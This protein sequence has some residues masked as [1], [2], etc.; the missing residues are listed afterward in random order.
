[1]KYTKPGLSPKPGRANGQRGKIKKPAVKAL[2]LAFACLLIL[3]GS[4][5]PALAGERGF[6]AD[7]PAAGQ[8]DGGASLTGDVAFL[9]Q[10]NGYYVMQVTV[11][12]SG[13][14]F[15]GT[16]QVVF[17]SGSSRN[18]AY[19]TQLTLPSQGK[20]QFTIHVLER[21][22]DVIRG[23]CSLNFLNEQG[24]LLQA[25]S[26]KNVFG[27]TAA[28]I[29]VG[30]L[31]EDYAGLT[32][33]DAGGTELYLQDFS[34]PLAL[35]ELTADNLQ[36]HLSG[37]Y[38]LVIDQFEVAALGEE[39]I[40]ALED[41]VL[42]GGCL[43]IGTGA[44]AEE[45][46]SGL[47][48]ELLGVRLG[49]VSEPGESNRLSGEMDRYG[50]YWDYAD[51]EV[52]FT[53]MTVAE[54][55]YSQ[56]HSD[57]FESNR[58]PAAVFSVGSG[59]VSVF[60]LSFG[61]EELQNL[62][63]SAI[64]ALYEETMYQSGRFQSTNGQSNMDY[65]GMRSLAF[66][67]SLHSNVDFKWLE[68]LIGVYVAAAGPVLYLILRKQKKS[69]WYWAAAPVLSL[70]FVAGV[71]FFGQGAR[72][73]EMKVYSITAQRADGN[74]EATSIL[75]YRSG[76]SP[77]E[78]QLEERYDV[79]G[80][81]WSGSYYY[82]NTNT[83]EYYYTVTTKDSG[84]FAG[85][86]PEAN[87]ESGYLYAEGAASAKGNLTGRGLR[88]DE[89]S[90]AAG[91]G[92]EGTITNETEY[93]LAYLAVWNGSDLLVFSEVKAGESLEL[94]QAMADGRCVFMSYANYYDNLLYELLNIYGDGRVG[95]RYEQDAMAALLVGIGMAED[96]KP[97]SVQNGIL[98]GVV[99][100]YERA[101]AGRYNEI[102][103]GCLYSYVET[104]GN[105]NA[106]D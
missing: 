37:L 8:Q 55:D 84:L 18:C 71:Y 96:K 47:G 46:L 9:R 42:N 33:L 105:G 67:D 94:G 35:V 98:V 30:I 59:S 91:N 49:G 26:L 4:G 19:N 92:A 61:E 3:M 89:N 25:V 23:L 57:F 38:F 104:E 11:E 79:A 95:D 102:S 32:Y 22:A 78:L 77:W 81:G 83:S 2:C 31:S 43:L 93:D 100:D 29:P 65:V 72:V 27:N 7:E 69:E 24:D 50:S 76:T 10:D 6:Y 60:F 20:K 88:L 54:L 73:N 85:I 5:R 39:N 58:H 12:N 1:M 16:V 101:T 99:S 15:S 75:A 64:E 97:D 52:D 48:E 53:R 68:I 14:D 82:N 21:A 62:H 87:F 80:P 28:G 40:R 51:A 63:E 17:A 106:A 70:V 36:S 90:L 74:R 103:Y 41:W 44:Y 86:K 45:T 13:P 66:L 56:V 34:S